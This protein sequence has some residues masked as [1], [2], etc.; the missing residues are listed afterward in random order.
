VSNA[1][2]TERLNALG[3]RFRTLLYENVCRSLFE[4]DKLM[5]SFL[6]ASAIAGARGDHSAAEIR[7][8]TTGTAA[9]VAA[10]AGVASPADPEPTQDKTHALLVPAVADLG[11]TR[12]EID[13]ARATLGLSELAWTELEALSTMPG[14]PKA[15][16]PFAGLA[17]DVARRAETWHAAMIAAEQPEA[18]PARG[19]PPPWGDTLSALRA[20]MVLR[21]MRP[22]R[23][24]AAARRYVVAELGD[25]FVTPPVFD[26]A[27][28][29]RA[30][31]PWQPL[32]FILSPGADPMSS[33]L[34]FAAQRKMAGRVATVSLGQ[35]QGAVATARIEAAV[36]AGGWVVLQ[37]CHLAVS[38]L[39]ELER[40]VAAL[41][42]RKPPSS[43]R[44]WLSSYPS[45]AFPVSVLQN[46]IKI[47]NEPPA[48]LRANVLRS[49]GTDPLCDET[50]WDGDAKELAAADAAAAAAAAVAATSSSSTSTSTSAAAAAAAAAASLTPA[51]ATTA[52]LG[53]GAG[54]TAANLAP[55]ATPAALR[56]QSRALSMRLAYALCFFHAVVQE[57]RSFG[58]LG[59]NIPYEF[60]ESDLRISVRQLK[61]HATA[62]AA[63]V[64]FRALSYLCGECNYGGRVTDAMDRRALL[65]ILADYYT[66]AILGEGARLAPAGPYT[67]PPSRLCTLAAG[68]TMAPA[69]PCRDDGDD[70]ADSLAAHVAHAAAMPVDESDPRV[71]G[72]HPNAMISRDIA[73]GRDLLSALLAAS[74]LGAAAASPARDDEQEPGAGSVGPGG[75]AGGG[76]AGAAGPSGAAAGPG[77]GAGGAPVVVVA[78]DATT[79]NDNQHQVRPGGVAHGVPRRIAR[80]LSAGTA[81]PSSSAFA[82]AVD[83]LC[84]SLLAKLPP[85]FDLAAVRAK[86]PISHGASLNAVLT[87]ELVR[88]NRLLVRVREDLETA[89]KAVRGLAAMS[90][91]TEA[92]ARAVYR[93]AIPD[94]WL[95]VSFPSERPVA[96]YAAELGAR[97]AFFA[98]WIE[99][100]PP[101]SFWIPGFFFTQ[102]F[103]TGVLSAHARKHEVPIDAIAF[104]F[105]ALDA[106]AAERAQRV[107]AEDGVHV[108]GLYLDG[109]SWDGAAGQLADPRPRELFAQAPALLFVP[110]PLD[111]IR[112]A[113]VYPCPFYRTPSRRGQ[114]STTGNSTNYVMN[115]ALPT[116]KPVAFWVKRGVALCATPGGGF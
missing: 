38:W 59:W 58:P 72:L 42:A 103:L 49:L 61:L 67:V 79:G 77:G 9:P 99:Q 101:A 20:M 5:F 43:F 37:N 56:A 71:F 1:V 23:V 2:T 12:A 6:L 47:T 44:L 3:E 46:A 106:A 73:R 25:K 64:P 116:D 17:A 93:G 87:Q 69:A 81:A 27:L 35:G 51:E 105:V 90:D 36:S 14:T 13:A 7:F 18:D 11:P 82:L 89:R 113:D 94:Q 115:V 80:L 74:A 39:P 31:A 50:Y 28:S 63:A 70:Y 19:L 76:A 41:P 104:D 92:V 75:G 15:P 83:T 53:P 29:Y 102:A 24:V 57:R 8:L 32:V 100:G 107:P 22:D 65:A 112:R 33:L 66:P 40:I 4:R 30:S 16:R 91:R 95:R 78:T 45:P 10:A 108:H 86:Y 114:L 85:P 52:G 96:A 111:E 84:T 54:G 88:Y 48:G 21:C 60:N 34:A 26:L 109:A 97:V 68:T 55:P 98:T 62:D 110:R